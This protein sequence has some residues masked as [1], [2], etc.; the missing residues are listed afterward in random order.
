M[1]HSIAIAQI[2]VTVGAIEQNVASMRRARAEAQTQGAHLVVYPE[3]TVCGYPPEDLLLRAGF[4]ADCRTAVES[5][6]KDTIDGPAMLIGSV[7]EIDG[8]VYNAALLLDGG[9]IVHV[10]PKQ[11]LPNYGV[12]DEKRLFTPGDSGEPVVWRGIALGILVCEDFWH[13]EI[14]QHL[15]SQGANALIVINASPYETGKLAVRLKKAEA[16]VIHTGIPL[17]YANLVGGQDDIVFDG[18]SFVMDATGGIIAQFPHCKEYVGIAHARPS[19]HS[20]EEDIW[21]AL[22]LGLQDYVRKN[23]FSGVLLGLSGGIDSALVATLAVDALGASGVLGVKLPSEHT[24]VDSNEDAD[25]L[26]LALG[27][28]TVTLPIA[29]T[30]ETT[31]AELTPSLAKVAAG[32]TEWRTHLAVGGNLQARLRGT[33]LMALSNATGKMLLSTSNKSEVAVGYSTLYGDSC[34]GFAPIKDVYKTQVYALAIWRNSIKPVIPARSIN[35]APTAELAPGQ[36]DQDQL[37]P[38]DV[39]DAMLQNYIE[40]GIAAPEIAQLIKRAEYKRRQMP[41]G[42]KISTML[43]GKDWRYPL[44]NGWKG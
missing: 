2:N 7:W 25:A 29:D 16:M 23:G 40:H 31:T 4:R 39:L 17:L 33:L 11:M 44:T 18:S 36:T 13:L 12:F 3:L 5:L 19:Q 27:I 32:F 1:L 20:A 8:L 10:Q 22:T 28:S 30:F 37:P 6:A 41:P 26:A 38:Y 9:R 43:F 35:K 15:A 34:G 21:R 24:S 14:G 42:T